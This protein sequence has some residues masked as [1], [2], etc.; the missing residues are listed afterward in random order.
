M[1][2]GSSGTTAVGAGAIS[3]FPFRLV[4]FLSNL[5]PGNPLSGFPGVGSSLA[6]VNGMDNT[7]V[8]QVLIVEPLNWESKQ[9]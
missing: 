4:D 1:Q 2:A 5:G 8:G 7:T 3:Q 6:F 9:Y